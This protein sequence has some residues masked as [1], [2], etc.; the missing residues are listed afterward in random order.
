MRFSKNVV[1]VRIDGEKGAG[2]DFCKANA[3][4]NYPTFILANSKGETMDRW[5]GYHDEADFI[6]TMNKA[7]V[8][9]LTFAERKA[10]F[11]NK[12][13]EIDAAKTGRTEPLRW[14]L[15]GSCRILPSSQEPQPDI[16]GAVR[17]SDPERDGSR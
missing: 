12:P 2:V 15:R 14:K 9:P 10:R 13:G 16:R 5:L 7:V 1:L 17:S 8:D 11:Q 3:I 4:W 6:K